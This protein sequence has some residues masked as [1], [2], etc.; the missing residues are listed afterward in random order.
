M[1]FLDIYGDRMVFARGWG[2]EGKGGYCL[3]S[4]VSVLQ[5]ERILE[6]MVVRVTQQCK[7]TNTGLYAEKGNVYVTC[8]L[9]TENPSG[10]YVEGSREPAQVRANDDLDEGGRSEDERKSSPIGGV[11]GS[12]HCQ[13]FLTGCAA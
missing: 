2:A 5:D 1:R 4:A 8:I 3:I 10:G 7:C 13:D 12:W 9:C 11:L 6:M